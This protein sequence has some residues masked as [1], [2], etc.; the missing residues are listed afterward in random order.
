MPLTT[1]S[2]GAAA[3]FL[4]G[5]LRLVG[6]FSVAGAGSSDGGR[7][8]VSGVFSPSVESKRVFSYGNELGLHKLVSGFPKC[9]ERAPAILDSGGWELPGPSVQG[10]A[11]SAHWTQLSFGTCIVD[12]TYLYPVIKMLLCN[13]YFNKTVCV[14]CSIHYR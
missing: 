1:S 4:R 7:K 8:P 10:S 6:E 14:T 12:V 3:G 2:T 5:G 11:I 9:V 13:I